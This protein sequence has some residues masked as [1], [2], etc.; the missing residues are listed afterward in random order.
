MT[1]SVSGTVNYVMMS[2][3]FLGNAC[4]PG[5]RKLKFLICLMATQGN[6]G[7]KTVGNKAVKDYRKSSCGAISGNLL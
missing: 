3:E 5:Y 7:L 4:I 2:F 6:K 1:L